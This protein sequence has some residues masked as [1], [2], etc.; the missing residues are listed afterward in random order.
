MSNDHEIGQRLA[1][2]A[3][4]STRRIVLARADQHGL[5][6]A[7]LSGRYSPVDVVL[8]IALDNLSDTAF[9][10]SHVP[11]RAQTLK[12]IVEALYTREKVDGVHLC[13]VRCLQWTANNNREKND[14]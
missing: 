6:V 1:W 13:L 4:F 2:V 8:T 3:V 5:F 14:Q 7:V 9:F 10:D 11:S 12:A